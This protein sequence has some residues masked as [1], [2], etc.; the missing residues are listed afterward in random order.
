MSENN[1]QEATINIS[2]NEELEARIK[3]NKEKY[4]DF[5]EKL[6]DGDANA[7][8]ETIMEKVVLASLRA[9]GNKLDDMAKK[10]GLCEDD[11][12]G[13]LFLQ[14]LGHK[15]LD[16]YK[17]QGELFS[18]MRWYVLDIVSKA[19]KKYWKRI[20]VIDP[21]PMET[22]LEDQEESKKS[23]IQ[24]DT[25]EDTEDA[26][27]AQLENAI[28]ELFKNDPIGA[29]LLLFHGKMGLTFNVICSILGL[30]QENTNHLT[31]LYWKAAKEIKNI[32][33]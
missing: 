23:R 11:I 30:T 10:V 15:K 12:L 1:E 17:Y 3:A 27:F 25:D 18:W 8:G 5:V 4:G 14:M 28:T 22:L 31:Y 19:Y 29:Y 7:W 16:L 21:Q 26:K 2:G 32:I 6:R 13:E 9:N 24:S 33:E 20:K